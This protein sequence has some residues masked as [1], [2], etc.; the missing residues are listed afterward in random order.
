MSTLQHGN[1]KDDEVYGIVDKAKEMGFKVEQIPDT[2]LTPPTLEMDD[3]QGLVHTLR[4]T[5]SD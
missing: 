5:K 1:T 2:Q 3:K 4:L